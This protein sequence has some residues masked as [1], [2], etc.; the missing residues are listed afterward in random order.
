MAVKQQENGSQDLSTGK[1]C[2]V[3]KIY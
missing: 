1:K 2:T 3:S